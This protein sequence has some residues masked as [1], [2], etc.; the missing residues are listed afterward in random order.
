MARVKYSQGRI[1]YVE[2]RSRAGPW[3]IDDS[4]ADKLPLNYLAVD[5]LTD[6]DILVNQW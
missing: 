2:D 3:I 4:T 5:K 1:N 6:L